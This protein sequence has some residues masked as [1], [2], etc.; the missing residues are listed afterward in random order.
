MDGVEESG[1]KGRREGRAGVGQAGKRDC[2]ESGYCRYRP[3]QSVGSEWGI[4]SFMHECNVSVYSKI[5]GTHSPD[6]F[7][8]GRLRVCI[9]PCYID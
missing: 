5:I 8:E 7:E 2:Q 1:R 9:C 6:E 4:D 3:S